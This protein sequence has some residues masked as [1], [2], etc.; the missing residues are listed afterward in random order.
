MLALYIGHAHTG[1]DQKPSSNWS[2]FGSGCGPKVLGLR[3]L[4]VA[5]FTFSNFDATKVA[6]NLLITGARHAICIN[7]K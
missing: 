5:F 3:C 6:P 4:V 7:A 2:W 1:K